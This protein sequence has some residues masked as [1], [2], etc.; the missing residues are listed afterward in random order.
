[1]EK[2]HENQYWNRTLKHFGEVNAGV[3][4]E[5]TFEYY[6]DWTYKSH[7]S[8]CGCITSKW[9]DNKLTASFDTKNKAINEAMKKMG[10]F[11]SE[12]SKTITV[13][14]VKGTST[15]SIPLS[16]QAIIYQACI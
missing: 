4:L 11:H 16:I 14:L 3:T 8:S 7:T 12:S 15:Q 2:Y 5:F 9:K 6:G 13:E 10:I 1:M